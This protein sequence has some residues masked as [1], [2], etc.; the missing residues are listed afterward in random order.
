VFL[1]V[2][3]SALIKAYVLEAGSAAVATWLG[4]ADAVATSVIA[5]AEVAAGIAK[6]VRTGYTK[7]DRARWLLELFRMSWGDQISVAA[8]PELVERA[9]EL[10]WDLGLRGYDAVHLASALEWQH[11]LGVPIV[12]VSFDHALLRAAAQCGLE[13]LPGPVPERG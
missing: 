12:L 4:A 6:G 11:T 5:R 8:T 2:D 3:S 1:Y 13:T 7:A 9:D 10:A